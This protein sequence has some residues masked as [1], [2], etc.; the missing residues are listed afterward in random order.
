MY[1]LNNFYLIYLLAR[2]KESKT[3]IIKIPKNKYKI[4]S[5]VI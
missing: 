3:K 5:S 4:S 2:A 1:L